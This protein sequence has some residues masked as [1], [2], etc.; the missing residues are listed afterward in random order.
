MLQEIVLNKL[1]DLSELKAEV[2]PYVQVF[3]NGEL[4]FTSLDLYYLKRRYVRQKVKEIAQQK[5][6]LTIKIGVK[7]QD[8]VL[9]RCRSYVS[10]D[11]RISLFRLYFHTSF[12]TGNALGFSK[13]SSA[14]R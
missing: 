11:K 3:K 5:L 9:L 1:P 7:V 8:D 13:V 4:V 14:S 10:E 2:A 6:P 12:V